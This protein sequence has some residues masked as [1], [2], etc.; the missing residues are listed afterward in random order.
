[1]LAEEA[2]RQ[3]AKVTLFLG[4]V[5]V[6]CLHKSI[7]LVRFVFFEELKNRLTREL[8]S[9]RYDLIIHSAAVSDFKPREKARGKI[10]SRCGLRLEL[11][12]LPK[13][14]ASISR[15]SRGARI[16]IFKLESGVS[17][18]TLVRRAIAT[19]NKNKADLV[20]ANQLEPYRAFIIGK[21]GVIAKVREKKELASRLFKILRKVG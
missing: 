15:L 21:E 16:V 6:C 12:A 2:S 14:I 11:V 10:S 18:A 13:I 1:M 17:A 3:G 20:V 7:R 9:G 8:K 19:G 4:P 5:P